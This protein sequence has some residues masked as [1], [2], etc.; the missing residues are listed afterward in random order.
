ML[1]VDFMPS[2]HVVVGREVRG[3]C[4]LLFEVSQGAQRKNACILGES[5]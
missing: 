2:G 3:C 4:S 5:W 1:K